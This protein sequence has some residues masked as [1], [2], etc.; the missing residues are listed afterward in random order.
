M[1]LEA[2]RGGS[3][4]LLVQA[5][6]ASRHGLTQALGGTMLHLRN[7]RSLLPALA[8]AM[9]GT[10]FFSGCAHRLGPKS[11]PARVARELGYAGCEVTESMRRYQTLDYADILGDPNLAD[12]PEWAKAV[13]MMQP[14]DELR[15]IYCKNGDNFF[16]L[17]RGTTL[18]L[19]FG[20]MIYD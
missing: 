2:E 3:L 7:S 18:L 14:G 4:F 5:A 16:G 12:S 17:F 20:G 19:R 9:L 6:A 15:Y 13:S 8:V 1:A 11:E 10:P